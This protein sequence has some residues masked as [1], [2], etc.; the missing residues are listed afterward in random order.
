MNTRSVLWI[1]ELA[2]A[3][4][5]D[6]QKRI[7][8]ILRDEDA[9]HLTIW[10]QNDVF[11]FECSSTR[12]IGSIWDEARRGIAK[13]V[14]KYKN[15]QKHANYI[16]NRTMDHFADSSSPLVVFSMPRSIKPV[17]PA[18]RMKPAFH[19][20]APAPHFNLSLY[21]SPTRSIVIPNSVI[22][23]G[24]IGRLLISLTT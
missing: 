13:D 16:I 20:S 21:F 23:E 22:F 9:T 18:L 24:R 5:D 17:R 11:R 10:L 19:L 4:I 15:W 14:M 1:D 7:V 2:V 12:P 3:N 6:S 8:I